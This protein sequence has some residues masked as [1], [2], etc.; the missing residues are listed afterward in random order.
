L[1]GQEERQ[2]D[3]F[4]LR[5]LDRAEAKRLMDHNIWPRDF[6]TYE[7]L[8]RLGHDAGRAVRFADPEGAASL[9]WTITDLAKARPRIRASELGSLLNLD[10]DVVRV[11]AE[12]AIRDD[13][14]EIDLEEG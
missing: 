5:R 8:L 13:G 12:R 3:V 10:P 7:A 14:V 11:L 9:R 1:V 4:C 6:D 2:N